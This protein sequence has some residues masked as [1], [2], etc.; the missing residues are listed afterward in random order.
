MDNGHSLAVWASPFCPIPLVAGMFRNWLLLEAK[1]QKDGYLLNPFSR[2]FCPWFYFTKFVWQRYGII[3]ISD[4]S[5]LWRHIHAEEKSWLY[6]FFFY[7]LFNGKEKVYDLEVRIKG[8]G[9]Q[10]KFNS[11]L[12]LSGSCVWNKLNNRYVSQSAFAKS[13]FVFVETWQVRQAQ[14]QGTYKPL[15]RILPPHVISRPYGVPVSYRGTNILALLVI[16]TDTDTS[17]SNKRIMWARAWILFY[18]NNNTFILNIP[19]PTKQYSPA[20]A[21]TSPF[22]MRRNS[23][24]ENAKLWFNRCRSLLWSVAIASNTSEDSRPVVR[25]GNVS[26]RLEDGASLVLRDQSRCTILSV[27]RKLAT[28]N[29]STYHPVSVASLTV[30]NAHQ[31]ILLKAVPNIYPANRIIA[32]KDIGDDGLVEYIQVCAKITMPDR[33]GDSAF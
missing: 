20:K 27:T 29:W 28:C 9:E 22:R 24:E 17:T 15:T 13:P 23:S 1:I 11:R 32:R 8:H 12:R 5:E 16:P 6:P 26:S 30:T 4:V 21:S 25:M 18:H 7:L 10:E 2:G 19:L 33:W 3:K 31:K 14:V